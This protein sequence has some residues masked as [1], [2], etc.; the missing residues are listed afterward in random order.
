MALSKNN[1]NR[2][3]LGKKSDRGPDFGDKMN[4]ICGLVC[5][6]VTKY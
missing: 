4:N 5:L 2:T 3:T 6:G 1:P